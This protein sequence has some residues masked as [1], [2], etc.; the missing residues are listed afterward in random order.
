[1]GDG[2]CECPSSE[3]LLWIRWLAGDSSISLQDTHGKRGGKGID[4]MPH[5]GGDLDWS[6]VS[7][8]TAELSPVTGVKVRNLKR[9]DRET[10]RLRSVETKRMTCFPGFDF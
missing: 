7:G 3:R 5:G 6:S 1:M 4:D 2:C 9:N 8:Y 10:F